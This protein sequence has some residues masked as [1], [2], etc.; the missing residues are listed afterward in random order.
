[1]EE[2]FTIPPLQSHSLQPRQL[3]GSCQ[4]H[5]VPCHVVAR[6]PN[7]LH[8][9]AQCSALALATL[10]TKRFAWPA[11]AVPALPPS[12]AHTCSAFAHAPYTLSWTYAALGWRASGTA[13]R[14]RP[15]GRSRQC[16][17]VSAVTACAASKCS[18]TCCKGGGGSKQ[19]EGDSSRSAAT[20]DRVHPML[21]TGFDNNGNGI[22]ESTVVHVVCTNT[23]CR[24]SARM[25]STE[26][27]LNRAAMRLA[28]SML[29][30]G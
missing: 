19:E 1:M 12:P 6:V 15:P 9:P 3:H 28:F 26:S 24:T 17:V 23:T 30:R 21:L 4:G 20:L 10:S 22:G 2:L 11:H 18:K 13:I 5:V 14:V 25:A 29:T 8:N 7:I 27:C 16:T